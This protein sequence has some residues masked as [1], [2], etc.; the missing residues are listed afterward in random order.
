MVADA[1]ELA[2]PRCAGSEGDRLAR[3]LLVRK[4]EQAGLDVREEAFTYDLAPALRAIRFALVSSALLVAAAGLLAP[5]SPVAA[6]LSLAGGILVG[7]VL[8]VWA[9]GTERLYARP[10][11]TRTAN[12]VARR[13]AASPGPIFV[14]LAHHDSKSQSLSLPWRMGLTLT[15]IGT[16]IALLVLLGTG[17]RGGSPPDPVWLP[18]ALG[19]TSAL[20]L[21][22]LST[23]R[24]GNDSPGGVDNAGSLAIL[25]ELART[26]PAE[27]P[28]ETDLVF[29]ATGAEEDHMVGAM[30]WLEAHR[31]ELTGRTVHAVNFDGAG[32]P[33]RVVAMVWYGLGQAFSPVLARAVRATAAREG[34]GLRSIWLPPAMGVDAIPFHHRGVGCLTLSSGSLGRATLAVHSARDVADHLDPTT[35]VE[36]ARLARAL[37]LDLARPGEGSDAEEGE[38]RDA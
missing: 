24:N 7:G 18:A 27:L 12:V 30:R 4:F 2:F 16:G 6:F 26:L 8:L 32:S 14:L 31:E 1:R 23:L 33:G 19:G 29:L 11:S 17:L 36:V 34:I 35:L 38:V 37:V 3:A 21:L 28:R 15:A 5:R 25:L 20:A 22:A 10:G 9:P 13:K